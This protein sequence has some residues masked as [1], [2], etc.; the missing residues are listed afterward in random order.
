[1]KKMFPRNLM[2]IQRMTNSFLFLSYGIA[3]TGRCN[4]RI[5]FLSHYVSDNFRNRFQ[6]IWLVKLEMLENYG[7]SEEPLFSSTDHWSTDPVRLWI[8]YSSQ[9]VSRITYL[10]NGLYY[11]N[12]L[13]YWLMHIYRL[14]KPHTVRNQCLYVLYSVSF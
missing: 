6:I 11:F 9:C 14:F 12:V 10:Q 13:L 7:F 4:D 3:V 5:F 8:L 2:I 1:M